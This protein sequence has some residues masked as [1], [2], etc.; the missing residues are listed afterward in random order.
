LDTYRH[1]L[2]GIPDIPEPI[3]RNL[4]EL[5]DFTSNLFERQVKQTALDKFFKKE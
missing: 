2:S 3:A 1:F 4:R 5:E